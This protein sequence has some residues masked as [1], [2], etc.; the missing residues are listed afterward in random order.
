MPVVKVVAAAGAI[1]GSLRLVQLGFQL[2]LG[3]AAFWAEFE[4]RWQ[5]VAGL[6]IEVA[7]GAAALALIL[8][9]P[10][11]LRRRSS[12]RRVFVAACAIM[13]L[14]TGLGMV[15]FLV[16]QLSDS[17]FF[18]GAGGIRRVQWAGYAILQFADNCVA[19]GLLFWLMSRTPLRSTFGE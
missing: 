5:N 8:S 9:V 17:G 13:V 16:N 10:G 11:C 15:V 12:A 18:G 3:G 14:A 6:F 19:P 7:G 4:D 1:F 2:T